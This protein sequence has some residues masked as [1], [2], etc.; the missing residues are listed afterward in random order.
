MADKLIIAI[1]GPCG[2]GKSTLSKLLAQRLGYVNI[3]TGAMYRCVA[4]AAQRGGVDVDDEQAL[5]QL[6]AG[7]DIHFSDNGATVWL[8]D[9]DVTTQLRTPQMS[10][11]TSK[12]ALSPAV[13]Q[14]MLHLQRRLGAAGGVV[15]EGRDIG[16]VVFPDA[17]VKFYLNASAEAR[18]R[19]R[20]EEL[21]AKGMPVKLDETIAA[22]RRR[23]AADSGRECAPLVKA[24]DAIE[25]DATALSIEQVLERMLQVVH[26]YQ[27]GAD[28]GR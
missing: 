23:D 19:R 13:R 16:S 7:L 15:L 9:E 3:N 10:M 14:A 12:V 28:G 18:G 4:L 17:Q 2:A 26:A 11:L 8:G 1:D 6:C 24:D 22:I 25:I 27:N 21:V 5:A 20:Y